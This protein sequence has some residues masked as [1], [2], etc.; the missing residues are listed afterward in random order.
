MNYSRQN[1]FD[2][3][4]LVAAIQVMLFHGFSFFDMNVRW[5][6]D[7]QMGVYLLPG[8]P[9]FFTISGFLIF[10]SLERNRS[11]LKKYF[12]NRALR[13][14]PALNVC[15]AFTI[16]LMTVARQIDWPLVFSTNFLSW[17]F[18]QIS[19]F[20]FYKIPEFA[21]W[22]VGHPNGSLWSISVEVQFYL[23]LPLLFL[24]LLKENLSLKKKNL[25]LLTLVVISIFFNYWVTQC[26]KG[27]EI[28]KNLLGL[29]ILKY[30]YFF[31]SGILIHLNFDFLRKYLVGKAWIW[32]PLFII[33]TIIF[34]NWFHLFENVYET[35]FA[36]I[37]GEIILSLATISA[38]YSAPWLSAR[39][40]NG[41][42]LSYGIYIYHMPI[43]NYF[44]HQ[45]PSIDIPTFIVI[46]LSIIMVSLLSWR[47]V[48]KNVLKL[49]SKIQI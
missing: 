27:S 31:C 8:V 20:Q 40:L 38:A 15:L 35:N 5:Q 29:F 22:G 12:I 42:D 49:K 25:I 23:V 10:Q 7:F 45:H 21:D 34:R 13:I 19:F 1:N 48:E 36:G 16:L 39:I 14:Y 6:K 41:N 46:C 26:F 24:Y 17:F 3:I 11:N 30:L 18:A 32:I 33:F 4:R 2:L 43:F 9:I 44:Y 37:L 28:L 47:V